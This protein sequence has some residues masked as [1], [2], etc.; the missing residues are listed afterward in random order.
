M[1]DF[2]SLMFYAFQRDDDNYLK[3]MARYRNE[4][5]VGTREADYYAKAMA[6]LMLAMQETGEE[7]LGD[8]YMEY[9]SSQFK[10]QFFTP[11]NICKMMSQLTRQ[12]RELPKDRTI[13]VNDPACGAGA[14]LLAFG[15]DLSFEENGRVL[16]IAQDIDLHCCQMTALN[17]MFYNYN[18]VIIQGDT[19]SLSVYG[20]WQTK[21]SLVYG[22]SLKT[23]DIEEAK[24]I[25]EIPFVNSSREEMSLEKI[26]QNASEKERCTQKTAINIQ[27]KERYHKIEHIAHKISVKPI[28]LSLFG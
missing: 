17:L 23:M 6:Q 26:G 16:F 27:N 25:I 3:I 28:Q 1:Q 14:M 13:T 5:K 15:K 9:A 21:R 20:A 7:Y 22:G 12:E 19:L 11:W 24:R 8:L 4:G 10:G 18:G 2:I